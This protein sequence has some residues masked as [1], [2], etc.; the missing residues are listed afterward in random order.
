MSPPPPS[1][2]KGTAEAWCWD[3]ILG[4]SWEAKTRPPRLPDLADDA[5]W[6][7]D[8]EPRRIEAPGRPACLRIETR[9]MKTPPMGALVQPKP[10]AQLMHT[11]LHHELQAAELFAWAVLAFPDSPREFRSGLLRLAMEELMHLGLYEG[12]LISLE[13]KV[14]DF[15][16]RDWFWQRLKNCPSPLAFVS[17]QGLGL[18]GANLDHSARFARAFRDAGDE[19]GAAIL[20]RVC[21]DEESHV[22]FSRRWF[23]TLS[24]APMTF[25]AWEKALP[26]LITP[27]LFRGRPINRAGRLGAGFDPEFI[28]ALERAPSATLPRKERL[29]P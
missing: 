14:G 4:D 25:E 13:H 24:G 8:A 29:R 2:P 17:L 11:F 3:L 9:S 7:S 26:D 23:E 12:H 15:P 10:R 19:K 1:P 16:V 27:G 21:K 6:E 22:D 18:E 20:D 28:D 5:C